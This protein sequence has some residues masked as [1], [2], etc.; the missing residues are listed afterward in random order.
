[1]RGNT[2]LNG[3]RGPV[4]LRAKG[5]L[6]VDAF[7][8]QLPPTNG[9]FF[10]WVTKDF[11]G[12]PT[13]P[14]TRSVQMPFRDTWQRGL[15]SSK[16]ACEP[17]PQKWSVSGRVRPSALAHERHLV[18]LGRRGFPRS[19]KTLRHSRRAISVSWC[20]ATWPWLQQGSLWE[21]GPKAACGC[22]YASLSSRPR[23]AFGETKSP[24]IPW[25]S[26]SS[27]NPR[28]GNAVSG[29]LATRC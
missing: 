25:V 17:Y 29:F 2:G 13:F 14:S 4:S 23:T 10:N 15:E 22:P 3:A 20:V 24:E 18:K 19:P 12:P 1:M 26:S 16:R 8:S 28:R 9:I 11:L 27:R 6:W 5:S 7:V 21:L